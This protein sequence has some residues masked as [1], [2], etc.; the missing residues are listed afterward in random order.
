MVEELN[1]DN[2]LVII[3]DVPVVA[4]VIAMTLKMMDYLNVY[5]LQ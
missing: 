4:G 5:V 2:T 1:K 3:H